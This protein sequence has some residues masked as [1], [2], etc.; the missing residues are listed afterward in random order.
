[1]KKCGMRDSCEKGAGMR[2]RNPHFQTLETRSQIPHPLCQWGSNALKFPGTDQREHGPV[3]DRARG[4]VTMDFEY[5][6]FCCSVAMVILLSES[7]LP[8]GLCSVDCGTVCSP[9]GI[10]K[11]NKI[12]RISTSTCSNI[13]SFDMTSALFF[14]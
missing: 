8:L 10:T 4:R 5:L 13:L 1:M 2:D 14:S 12:T 9:E 7:T 3:L 11:A 6:P